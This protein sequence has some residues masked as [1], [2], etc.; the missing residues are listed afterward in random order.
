MCPNLSLLS[1]ES[2]PLKAIPGNGKS[3]RWMVW[4]WHACKGKIEAFNLVLFL[5]CWWS[6]WKMLSSGFHT[7]NSIT[8]TL[9]ELLF[10]YFSMSLVTIF[11]LMG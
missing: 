1:N 10:M 2:Y 11:M 5:K 6:A 3:K 9:I 4:V 8:N 7:C